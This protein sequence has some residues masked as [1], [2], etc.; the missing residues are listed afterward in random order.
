MNQLQKMQLLFVSSSV[1]LSML[2]TYLF[3]IL[4]GLILIL[5]VFIGIDFWV[6]KRQT[7]ALKFFGLRNADTPSSERLYANDNGTKLNYICLACGK[8]VSGRTCRKCG[9]HMKKAVF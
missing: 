9:S 8:K 2:A 7:K 4:L 3:G 6:R 1:G 5:V